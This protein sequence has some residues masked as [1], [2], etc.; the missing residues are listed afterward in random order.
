MFKSFFYSRQYWVWAY[1][2]AILLISVIVFQVWVSTKMN[3]W[4]GEFYNI[5]QEA[6][7]HTLD[8]FYDYMIN[9]SYLA[10]MSIIAGMFGN[11]FARIYVLRW[12]EA[13]TF[14]YLPHWR[15]TDGVIEGASQRIQEDMFRFARIVESLGLQFLRASMTLIAFVPILWG[16]SKDVTI[17]YFTFLND[18]EGSLVYVSLIISLGGLI[19]SWYVGYFLPKLEYNNQKVEA[20][21]RKELVLAEDDRAKYGSQETV[22]ELFTG[23]KFNYHRLYLH[24]GYFDLWVISYGQVMII[25]PYLLMAPALFSGAVMI[26]A[27]MQTSNAFGRVHNSFSLLIDNWTVITELRSVALRLNEFEKHIGMR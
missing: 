15:N 20:A 7:K 16:L 19:I 4:Y 18:V 21:F 14:Y 27:L 25:L 17:P 13:M 1:L 10:F 9:F 8:D 6:T 2:G 23:I 12:R 3:T 5:L 22:F 11:Y 24:Y 26:G